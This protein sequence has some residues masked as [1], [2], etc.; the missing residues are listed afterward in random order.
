MSNEI[1]IVVRLYR[2]GRSCRVV[3]LRNDGTLSRKRT[4]LRRLHYTSV[5][6]TYAYIHIG[7]A[8]DGM[9][10][11]DA[12]QMA[13][14]IVTT[15]TK[16]SDVRVPTNE[17]SCT[18]CLQLLRGRGVRSYS[19]PESC[20]HTFCNR[21]LARWSDERHT[22]PVCRETYAVVI[23]RRFVDHSV[24]SEVIHNGALKYMLS[25]LNGH[26]HHHHHHREQ[27]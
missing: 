18:I 25:R 11:F 2:D 8:N 20:S 23:R 6:D 12:M 27:L 1:G 17:A 9:I 10:L 3:H 19:H 21:C 4:T 22:C 15:G 24:Q 26:H 5:S 14:L 13:R 16:V 7:F